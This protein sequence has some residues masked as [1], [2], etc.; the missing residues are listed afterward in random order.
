MVCRLKQERIREESQL[1]A[2]MHVA[3]DIASSKDAQTAWDDPEF[4][5]AMDA[6]SYA[7][8][9]LAQTLHYDTN[10]YAGDRLE[11]A[12]ALVCT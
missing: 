6:L 2:A 11:E 5:Q 1:C 7:Q 3:K 9:R 4:L 8:D 10:D 12:S